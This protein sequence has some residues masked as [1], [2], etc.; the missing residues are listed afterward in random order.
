M[1]QSTVNSY[2]FH[3]FSLFPSFQLFRSVGD[4]ILHQ[5]APIQLSILYS[6]PSIRLFLQQLHFP[7]FKRMHLLMLLYIFFFNLQRLQTQAFSIRGRFSLTL[8]VFDF[9]QP[10]QAVELGCY[11]TGIIFLRRLLLQPISMCLQVCI[12]M[13]RFGNRRCLL[14]Q[15]P[16]QVIFTFFERW[17]YTEIQI[18][19]CGKRAVLDLIPRC[20]ALPNLIERAREHM[21]AC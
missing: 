19:C 1:H 6:T 10:S 15:D 3:P 8:E 17:I 13:L 9:M 18:Q 2:R 4:L 12:S 7:P 11:F 14:P 5:A 21:S 16:A 20:A